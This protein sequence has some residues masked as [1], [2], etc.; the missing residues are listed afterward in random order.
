TCE[1]QSRSYFLRSK[2]HRA[3]SD[4]P[5]ARASD[6]LKPRRACEPSLW[7]GVTHSFGCSSHLN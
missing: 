1:G 3:A 2:L 7:N 4:S 6:G 5:G